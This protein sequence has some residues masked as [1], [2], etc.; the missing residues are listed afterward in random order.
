VQVLLN[1]CDNHVY[2]G[3]ALAKESL[4][5]RNLEYFGPTT[6]R[7]TISHCML[8]L[9]SIQPGEIVC[10]PMCGS[11]SIVVEGIVSWPE[12]YFLSGDIHEMAWPRTKQNVDA[13]N[14][15]MLNTNRSLL[16]ADIFQWDATRLPLRNDSLDVIVTDL[17]FGKK[18]GSKRDNRTL[19]PKILAEF[20]RVVKVAKGRVVFLTA[21]R[22]HIFRALMVK[23]IYWNVIK[24]ID[25]NIGGLS[26]CVCLMHRNYNA[27]QP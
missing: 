14:K 21:D 22:T 6:L 19:Y 4:H 11:G 16:T 26:G 10:D 5:R 1:I 2:V 23:P 8:R 15:K 3:L 12:S 17:P 9:A 24:K 18:M 13:I 25:V 20:G 27:Y 7:P